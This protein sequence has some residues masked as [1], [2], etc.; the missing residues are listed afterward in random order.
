MNDEILVLD[1]VCVAVVVVG[2]LF[3]LIGVRNWLWDHA[4][5]KAQDKVLQH[6]QA[7]PDRFGD[8]HTISQSVRSDK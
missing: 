7:D 1:W 3:T 4:L 8:L 6:K 2:L 5:S